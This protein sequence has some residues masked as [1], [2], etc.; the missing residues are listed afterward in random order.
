MQY[1]LLFGVLATA[2]LQAQ[3]NV[4]IPSNPPGTNAA[5]QS[6]DQQGPMAKLTDAEKQ[7]LKAAHDKAIAADPA[8]EEKLEEVHH[9]LDAA[10]KAMHAAMI[11][12]DPSVEAI[13]AKIPPPKWDRAIG[14][15]QR[16]KDQPSITAQPSPEVPPQVT[17]QIS[18]TN[19]IV[20]PSPGNDSRKKNR[21]KES[22]V[23]AITPAPAEGTATQTAKKPGGNSPSG[24]AN[25]SDE[26]RAQLKVLHEKV[27]DDPAVLAAQENLKKANSP[28]ARRTASEALHTIIQ[29]AMIKANPE[30][31]KVLGKIHP[32]PTPIPSATP[33]S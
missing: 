5:V 8:L 32:K 13:L 23:A 2:S 10:R 26:E 3:T 18:S 11:Q 29:E 22:L 9:A 7:Q 15:K 16:R 19:V 31:Q 27:K 17:P 6:T 24:M 28:E 12:A 20:A 1:L 25:V 4:S 33:T 30:V 21:G 14:Q